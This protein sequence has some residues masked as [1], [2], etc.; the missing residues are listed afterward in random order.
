MCFSLAWIENLLIW[1]VVIGAVVGILKIVVPLVLG[2]LGVAGGAIIQIINIVVWAVVIIFVIV[3]AFDLI[4]C[5]MGAHF[6]L[7]SP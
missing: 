5:L 1:L 2:Y 7:R 3:L 6:S 4:G